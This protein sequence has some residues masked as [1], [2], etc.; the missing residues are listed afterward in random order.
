MFLRNTA[1][2][3]FATARSLANSIRRA[4]PV[5]FPIKVVASPMMMG[6]WTRYVPK[7][8]DTMNNFNKN[9]CNGCGGF[10]DYFG[11]ATLA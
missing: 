4:R 2:K 10:D 8:G 9:H 6:V 11:K 7:A 1:L 5:R 3:V